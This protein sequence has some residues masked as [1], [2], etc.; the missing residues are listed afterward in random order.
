MD[1]QKEL[2]E[3]LA[4]ENSRYYI[5]TCKGKGI[6]E[7]EFRKT[8]EDDYTRLLTINGKREQVEGTFLEVGCGIGRMTE[9]IAEDWERVVAIDI[10]GEMIK[11][12]KERLK[13]IDNIEWYET[14]GETVPLKDNSVDFA[15]SY[16]VFQHIKTKGMIKRNFKEVCRVL[17]PKGTF[18]VFLRHKEEPLEWWSGGVAYNKAT[19]PE[20]LNGFTVKRSNYKDDCYT[21]WLWLEK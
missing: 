12:G 8:G 20:I 18:L 2:W 6:T 5:A 14:D 1:K 17:K 11:Q 13:D 16:L 9:F 3:K 15:F 10:S 7:A 4:K 21:F 19:L